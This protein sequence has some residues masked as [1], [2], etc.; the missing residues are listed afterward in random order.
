[1]TEYHLRRPAVEAADLDARRRERPQAHCDRIF[2]PELLEARPM[3][4]FTEKIIR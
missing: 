1:M 2:R 4:P 3:Q